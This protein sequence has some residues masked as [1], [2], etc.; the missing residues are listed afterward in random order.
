MD[1]PP[2]KGS[3]TTYSYSILVA[4]D[5]V[6]MRNIIKAGLEKNGFV[7]HTVGDGGAALRQFSEHPCD[8]VILDI[9]MPQMDGYEV[10]RQLRKRTTV[11]III[12]TTESHIDDVVSGYELGADI[13]VTKP[14]SVH[15][16][17]LRAQALLRRME[18]GRKQDASN[19]LFAG[20]IVVD[21]TAHQVTIDGEDVEL[22]PNEYSMLCFFMEHPN[23]PIE[24]DELLREVWGYTEEDDANLLRVTVRRLRAKIEPA[25]SDPTYLR[26]VRGTGYIFVS[27]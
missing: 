13:Y 15:E 17:V 8:L 3:N 21:R 19:F 16:L 11:P 2:H 27:P 25:P 7:V 23:H 14:F 5:D 26:T 6:V 20:N 12:V 4:E 1:A 10:C 18:V 9:R 24:K 22:T